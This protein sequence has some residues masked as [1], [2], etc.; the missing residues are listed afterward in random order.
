MSRF[1]NQFHEVSLIFYLLYY[2]YSPLFCESLSASHLDEIGQ[3][4]FNTK[5]FSWFGYA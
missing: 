3:I 2:Q 1:T 5:F 4:V